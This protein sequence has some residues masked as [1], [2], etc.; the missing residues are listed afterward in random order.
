MRPRPFPEI[1]RALR[2]LPFDAL[3]L[4]GELVVLDDRGAAELPAPAAARP[5]L[6]R[7]ST[8][9]ARRS[10]CPR[11]SSSST[12][13]AS[14]TSTCAACRW[15]TRKELLQRVLPRRGPVRYADHI[16]EHGR[17]AASSRSPDWG[18]RASSAKTADSPY[19]GGR[20]PTGSR[21]A[22][23]ATGDFVVVGL[24]AAR[25]RRARASARCTW[26]ATRDGDAASTPAASAPASRTSSCARSASALEA[27]RAQDAGRARA[28]SRQASGPRLGRARARVRGALQGV[29]AATA[30]CATRSSCACATTSGRRSACAQRR[31]RGASRPRRATPAPSRRASTAARRRPSPLSNLDKVFWPEERLHQGRPDRVLPRDRAVAAALPA[32]TGRSC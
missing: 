5:L 22:W 1:A 11:R 19:R 14:R 15:S 29:D 23:T 27:A 24:L 31:R 28:R 8:S 4:D 13:S 3:V 30:C 10:S 12:C 32:R 26:R 17:G 18:S 21:S 6:Q 16:E 20:S 9:S 7:R 2:A 25:G